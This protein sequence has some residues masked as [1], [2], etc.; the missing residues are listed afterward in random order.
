MA[1][2]KRLTDW[3]GSEQKKFEV[4]RIEGG[5]DL[6]NY[7]K[8]LG[9]EEGKEVVFE[10]ILTHEHRGPL[11]IEVDGKEVI[12]AQ[13]IAN[14]VLVE[15]NGKQK[16][17]LELEAGDSGTIKGFEAGKAL[18]DGLEKLGLKERLN[19]KVKG[20]AAEE[21]YTIEANGQQIELCIGEASKLLVKVG[22][23]ILQLCH[24]EAGSEGELIDVI[25]G[26]ALEERL[27]KAGIEKGKKI[28][29][30][31]RKAT[32]GPAKHLGCVF[33]LTVESGARV[34]IGHGM[35]EKIMVTPVE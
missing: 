10:S 21:A 12:L 2:V 16:R 18:K 11:A 14:R 31:S 17:L 33:Y 20:H 25:S 32:S 9:I 30:A 1:E 29:L 4:V 19:V 3:V 22:D 26:V 27:K 35:A 15:V 24:L 23:N 28:K 6:K 7:L 13:G 8:E 34:S 5:A